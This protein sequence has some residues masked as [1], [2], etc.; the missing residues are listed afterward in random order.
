MD[1][2]DTDHLCRE[3]YF[4]AFN[5]EEEKG[6][7]VPVL[8]LFHLVTQAHRAVV[9]SQV[10]L[11]PHIFMIMTRSVVVAGPADDPHS[12]RCCTQPWTCG[13]LT[14]QKCCVAACQPSAHA[15]DSAL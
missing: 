8:V 11:F 3:L 4:S 1:I 5:T 2:Y 13:L 15:Q 7:P 12:T 6:Y 14:M 10:Q 9:D